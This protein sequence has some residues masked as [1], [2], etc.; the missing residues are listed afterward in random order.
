MTACLTTVWTAGLVY[1]TIPTIPAVAQ[2][3]LEQARLEFT[4]QHYDRV[5]ELTE[6]LTR[7]PAQPDALRLKVRSLARLG[8]PSDALAQYDRLLSPAKRDDKGLLREVAIH[9]ITVV[10][11]DMRE[12]MRG[13]GFTALKELNSDEAIPYFEDGLSDGSGFVR[14]LAV[15]G[16]GRL[17]VANRSPGVR[18]A[19]KDPAAMVRL[20][21]LR[22]LGRSGD[23]SAIPWMEPAL[24]DEQPTVRIAAAGALIM[25]GKTDAKKYLAEAARA[26]NP[27]ERGAALRM[28][29]ELKDDGAREV[30]LQSLRDNQPSV[31]GAAAGAL[32]DLGRREATTA[33]IEALHDKMPLVRSMAAL[34]LG[35]LSAEEGAAALTE[36]LADLNPGVRAAAASA[37]F[38]LDK[39]DQAVFDALGELAR[40]TDPGV[41]ASAARALSGA[42]EKRK[43]GRRMAT[44]GAISILQLLLDDPLPRP[45]IAAARALGHTGSH[46]LVPILKKALRDQDEAVR[47]TAAG[48]LGRILAGESV[49]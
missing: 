20:A 4:R 35:Q 16:L 19:L 43:S 13:A 12:Q 38:R 15:E 8:R 11:K 27:E 3:A 44:P 22:A 6:A 24:T 40:D 1:L 21:A 17:K 46:Q 39:S 48:A 25:L 31:R 5:L 14:T 32:G 10:L 49:R 45:R 37:L 9:F 26:A 33:L 30:L 42:E 18:T 47:A 41:R 2:D 29:G 23:R 7:D 28:L 36:A 34:A